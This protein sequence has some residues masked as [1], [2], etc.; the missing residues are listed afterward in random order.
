MRSMRS[1]VCFTL[2]TFVLVLPAVPVNP[3]MAVTCSDVHVVWARGANLGFSAFDWSRFVDQDL[4]SR[5]GPGVAMTDYQL[6]NPGFGGF[7]YQPV[8]DVGLILE[9]MTGSLPFGPFDSSV[10]TGIN[11]L[12]AYLI[13]R[14]SQC[15][16][17]VY[18]LGGYSE[19]ADVVGRSLS[20]LPQSVRDRVAFAALFGD[21]VLDTGNWRPVG[22]PPIGGFL[23]SCFLGKK[24]WVRGSAPCWITGGIFG[25]HTPYVPSDME[26]R[27]GS[28]CRDKDA[29]CVGSLLDV[30]S[31][32]TFD[33]PT[34]AHYAYFDPNSDAAFA[35]Q[36]AAEHL[37][38]FVPAHAS[39]FDVTWDQFVVGQTGAD[40]VIA[41]DTTGSMSGS[42]ADAKTQ[43]TNLANQWTTLFD[44]GRV[45]LV[46]F[47][48]VNQG[49]PY[50]S[51]V[52][53]GLT[54][55]ASAFQ[56]AVN[57]LSAS[58]GGDT[59]EAQLS[60]I[61]SALDGMAWAD[62]AT[63]AVVV[64]TD[65]PGKD[66]EPITNFTRTSVD[67][68]ALQIDP[69]AIYG[70]NVSTLQSVADWMAPMASATAGEV[71]TLA[72]GQSLSDAL[73]DLFD[74]V[75][76]NPVAKLGGPYIAQTGTGINFSAADA[77]DA[78]AAITSYKWDFDGNGTVD[79]TTTTPTTTYAYP[80][81]FQGIASVE[82]VADDGRSAIAT[83]DVTVDS[84]GLANLQP[85]A[86]T[87][88][89][90][91]PTG[92]NQV[93]L[94]WTPAAS[95]RADGY[96]IYRSNST[97][98]RFTTAADPHSVVLDGIDLSQPT[99]FYVVASNGYGDSATVASPPVGG[100]SWAP[101]VV[102]SNDPVVDGIHALMP[103][104]GLSASNTGLA[105]WA[106][107][108]SGT[109]YDIYGSL[110]DP[111]SGAWAAP[112]RINDGTTGAQYYPAVAF[113]QN[114]N[115]Y[116]VWV[117]ERNGR[118]DI[119]FSKR[120]AATGVWSANVRVNSD[121]TFSDQTTPA[122]A[123][124]S[125]GEAIAVWYRKVGTNKY[126]IYSG[127]LPAGS[128]TWSTS[129]KVTPSQSPDRASPDVSFGPDGTAYAVWTEPRSGNADIWFA[130]LPSGSST[131]STASK[132]SDD[133]GTTF[134]GDP[135]IGVDGAGN[136]VVTWDDWRT[137]PHQ[138]RAR[139]RPAGG[140]WA[141]SVVVSTNGSN[142]PSL[143][144]GA[145]GQAFVA[146]Q[147]GPYPPTGNTHV[148]GSTFD[149]AAG[150]WSTPV[151]LDDGGT[152]DSA[153]QPAAGIAGTKSVL[154]WQNATSLQGGGR[155][156]QIWARWK[157]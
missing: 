92:A 140:A 18:V 118:R 122:I 154:V 147:D 157:N 89:I 142:V 144:V 74:S 54:S 37:Q 152:N 61:M 143:S 62:G 30:V 146:W 4:R 123:V 116:A 135:E 28:W 52:D 45:G 104:V 14:S 63:K 72:P 5:I 148:W 64:I 93:T 71:V 13:D 145:G 138:V 90:A 67:Q 87:S 81:I 98:M 112:I 125:T 60:G 139:R 86:P 77:F 26:Q 2:M 55:D 65:A 132:I 69:V 83:T 66:P 21:P 131:W 15:A 39:S 23:P 137:T 79:R 111:T 113:D 35:A 24:P 119:Y 34:R 95:D 107:F 59:P 96:K 84:V 117:D 20:V 70:V 141:A 10:Q 56:T 17:E 150:T 105:L 9:G 53:L 19:G 88:A 91:T 149:P 12:N 153:S 43:A 103:A 33:P 82:V 134:Q 36:E 128:S 48:D 109:D 8:D 38:T 101:S 129:F 121:T 85:L 124:S 31:G 127:R 49:D 44:N 114:S 51:R 41:F 78:S 46:D 75:H 25:S 120:P 76:A 80:G 6:G 136:V 11:E 155:D 94:T 40:L 3:V 106:R 58:G 97:P 156:N 99:Q 100:T 27:V 50:A 115:A 16:N 110:R 32:A 29:A 73:S 7:T 126:Y 102:V 68:H 130:S 151:R 42:I 57:G 22:S 1:R 47:K 108:H 133:P